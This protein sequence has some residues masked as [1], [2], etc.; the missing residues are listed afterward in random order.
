MVFK[1]KNN[2]I[3]EEDKQEDEPEH[4]LDFEESSE[5]Q[6]IMLQNVFRRKSRELSKT[7]QS[8]S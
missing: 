5:P 4:V 2:D 8:L 6:V 7:Q 1:I 3:I